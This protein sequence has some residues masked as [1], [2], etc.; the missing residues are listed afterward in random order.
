MPTHLFFLKISQKDATLKFC[1]FNSAPLSDRVSNWSKKISEE[2]PLTP[3]RNDFGLP[4]GLKTGGSK[5][6]LEKKVNSKK[7]F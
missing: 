2:S 6:N 3:G 1:V 4:T 7:K 5:K